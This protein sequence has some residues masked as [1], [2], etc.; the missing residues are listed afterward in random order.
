[1]VRLSVEE[2]IV[3]EE[4]QAERFDDVSEDSGAS[5]SEQEFRDA[6]MQIVV[7]R[8]D[9]LLPNLI[10]MLMTHKTLEVSP[11][12]QRRARWDARRKS[13]LIESFLVNIPIPPVFLYENEF[14]RYEVYGWA[15]AHHSDSGVL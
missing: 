2:Q 5:V 13:K 9:F 11:Y 15:A 8:N 10:D 12:Y 14:A 4:Y 1:M 6:A 7:Q 3:K